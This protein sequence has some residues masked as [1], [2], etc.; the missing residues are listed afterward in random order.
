VK[1][2]FE[3]YPPFWYFIGNAANLIANDMSLNLSQ[4]SRTEFKKRALEYFEKFETIEQN[5]ILREDVLSASCALEHID[6]L[7]SEDSYDIA[8]IKSLLQKAVEMSGNAFDILQ[9][10]AITYLKI[11]CEEE[12]VK[13]L[14]NLVNENYNRII[15]AQMLSAIYVHSFDRYRADYEI[16]AT[17]IPPQYLFPI[18]EKTSDV[19]LLEEE[20][21]GK[22]RSIVKQELQI[23]LRNFVRKYEIQWNAILS[24]FE[25]DVSYPDEFFLEN[26]IS[27]MKRKNEAERI[28]SNSRLKEAYQNRLASCA[29]ES[30]VQKILNEMVDE[31]FKIKLFSAKDIQSEVEK[32]IRKEIAKSRNTITKIHNAIAG[33]SFQLAD[34]SFAQEFTLNS[35]VG[36]A[37][38]AMNQY[39]S[40]CMEKATIGEIA[41]V[42]SDLLAFC[43]RTGIEA[44]EVVINK[45]YTAAS[46]EDAQDR[47]R[48]ELFGH[49]AVV[50]QRQ[51]DFLNSMV[52]FVKEQAEQIVIP[53]DKAEILLR[54]SPKFNG[55]F[56][57]AALSRDASIQAHSLMV[58][59]DKTWK[60]NDLIFTTD[61]IV[62]FRRG[63]VKYI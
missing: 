51:A 62:N 31:L 8:K 16:L 11:G 61:G 53:D 13:I 17:R 18:P 46:T 41:A 54:D 58:L 9:L 34:Y 22:Q 37:V 10:C 48:S 50:E 57:D 40:E 21:E 20:F 56:Q 15:N 1:D 39:A 19:K 47:F 3:A 4:A 29:F 35:L 45:G 30:T 23:C 24:T 43:T 49:G 59:H 2:K 38:A 28:F 60:R 44:P 55:Y 25:T 42:E 7:L 32:K 36:T 14:R 27:R 63:S 6:L 5:S 12:A 52:R 26:D 33:R